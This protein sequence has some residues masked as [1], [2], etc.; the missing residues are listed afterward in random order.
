MSV[1]AQIIDLLTEDAPEDDKREY[2]Y[3]LVESWRSRV[4]EP[5]AFETFP[6]EYLSYAE[7]ELDQ[8]TPA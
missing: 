3:P 8:G 6:R 7:T 1:V 2:D 4:V 5:P